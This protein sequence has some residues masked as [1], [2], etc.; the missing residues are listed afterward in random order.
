MVK[1][2]LVEDEQI[3]KPEVK[4][5]P[6]LIKTVKKAKKSINTFEITKIFIDLANTSEFKRLIYKAIIGKVHR[7][8][9]EDLDQQL[10]NLLKKVRSN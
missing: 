7:G 4:E 2:Q 1:Y 6:K 8:S 5:V 3:S 9:S 10:S